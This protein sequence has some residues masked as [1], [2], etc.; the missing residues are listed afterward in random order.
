MIGEVQHSAEHIYLLG[1]RT[2]WFWVQGFI[3]TFVV[4]TIVLTWMRDSHANNETTVIGKIKH[5]FM[6]Y[7][8][9]YMLSIF[10]SYVAMIALEWTVDL[11][12]KYSTV[13]LPHSENDFLYFIPFS[14]FITYKT[15]NR[16]HKQ[17]KVNKQ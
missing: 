16:F 12:T 3:M 6:H 14:G 17:I 5:H 10:A 9:E 2:V 7:G 8:K 4:T 13:K 15:H 1:D 11:L